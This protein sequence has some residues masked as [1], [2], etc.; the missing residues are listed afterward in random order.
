MNL[1]HA[2][3]AGKSYLRALLHCTDNVNLMNT[4]AEARILPGELGTTR[5]RAGHARS[6][7]GTELAELD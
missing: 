1:G 3:V 6:L 2:K 5:K 7:R 4:I